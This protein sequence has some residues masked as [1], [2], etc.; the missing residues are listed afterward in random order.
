[1]KICIWRTGH[2]IADTVAFAAHA[3][4]KNAIIIPAD[5]LADKHIQHFDLH[6]GYGILRGMEE[7]F[8]ECERQAKPWFEIDKGYWRPGHYDGYYRVSLRGTQ[9]TSGW[10][11]LD[12]ERWENLILDTRPLRHRMEGPPLFY[13]L[14][15]PPTDYVEH[16]FGM[17][18]WE[19]LQKTGWDEKTDWVQIRHK[20]AGWDLEDD[21]QRASRVITFNSSVGWEALRR[22]I[23][24]ESDPKHSIVGAWQAQ[25]GTD[26]RRDLF[27]T[28]AG[29][30]LTLDEMR[31][32]Q[33]WPLMQKLLDASVVP[34][35]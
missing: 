11:E 14:V 2:E 10:P 16:F 1:M 29:L 28:M 7:V 33:L 8:R 18:K 4:L 35:V 31:Q 17:K 32:G 3:G 9:Q 21:M 30:Q 12:W 24:V 6:I 19:W 27:A 13:P 22:G 25:H 23:S 26:K 34:A 15:C 20:S 5:E